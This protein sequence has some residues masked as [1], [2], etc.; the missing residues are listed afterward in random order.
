ML[1]TAKE[2][3]GLSGPK[4]H[5]QAIIEVIKGPVFAAGSRTTNMSG[6]FTSRVIDAGTGQ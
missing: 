6:A 2:R 5:F 1:Y 4:R 3:F